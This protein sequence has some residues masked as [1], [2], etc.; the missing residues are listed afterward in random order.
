[1]IFFKSAFTLS[2]VLI[3]LGIIGVVAAM[4]LPTIIGVSKDKAWDK[5][6]IVA[7]AKLREAANQMKVA[8]RFNDKSSTEAF[9]NEFSR[10]MKFV[11]KCDSANLQSCYAA[12]FINGGEGE[13]D[14]TLLRTS[15]HLG[16]DDYKTKT[17]GLVIADG[18]AIILAYDPKCDTDPTDNN[19]DPLACLSIV[20]DINGKAKPNKI[21]RDIVTLNAVVTPCDFKIGSLCTTGNVAYKKI[22]EECIYPVDKV[23]QCAGGNNYWGGARDACDALGMRLPTNSELAQ[24][25]SQQY[26]V[27]FTANG[28]MSGLT[29]VDSKLG[30]SGTYWASNHDPS[31]AHS[32]IFSKTGSSWSYNNM[33]NNLKLRCVK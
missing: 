16:H 27:T 28:S 13:A 6:K 21:G 26:G 29:I 4:T 8:D 20:Y 18:T 5:Q 2:E 30:L 33:N 19:S 17:M 10:Y 15:K 1:M 31:L 25:A 3:T 14:V 11:N 12:K 9:V 23:D 32:R 24:M 22:N 7:E